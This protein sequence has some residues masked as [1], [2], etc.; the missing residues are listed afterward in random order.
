MPHYRRRSN[1]ETNN[2]ILNTATLL[3]VAIAVAAL[4]GADATNAQTSMTGASAART[5]EMTI[6]SRAPALLSL[7]KEPY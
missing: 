1:K 7:K 6:S 2:L 5:K 3:T 4:S